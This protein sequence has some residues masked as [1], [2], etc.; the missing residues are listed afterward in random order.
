MASLSYC[1]VSTNDP[2]KA[3]QFYDGLLGS[4]GWG[5]LFEIP[6]RGRIYG[7]GVSMLGVM[8]PYDGQPATFGNGTMFGVKF[9]TVE[10][11]ASFH[12][13]ALELGASNEGDPGERMPGA[14]FAYFRDPEGNKLC[15]Y[16]LGG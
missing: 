2:D 13:K 4:I 12:A 10:E 16:S 9:D 7:D 15:G 1:T 5:V 3:A 6:E 8:T 14:Q 11:V